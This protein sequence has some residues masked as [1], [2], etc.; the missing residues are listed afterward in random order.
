MPEGKMTWALV[1]LLPLYMEP[2]SGVAP[3]QLWTLVING[4]FKIVFLG[5][6]MYNTMF[7]FYRAAEG[8]LPETSYHSKLTLI[9]FSVI[10]FHYLMFQLMWALTL[11]L[12]T[13]LV[14]KQDRDPSGFTGESIQ[15]D[16]R[17]KG[18]GATI[19]VLFGIFTVIL[20]YRGMR[21]WS[22]IRKVSAKLII[23]IVIHTV[24]LILSLV[25][26]SISIFYLNNAFDIF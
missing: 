9:P 16:E 22:L 2:F 13:I 25:T 19:V 15:S 11:V 21:A 20:M 17:V 26:T 24:T 23:Q 12:Y 18:L 14:S 10:C 7:T 8:I 5:F 3:S 4:I 6:F 1:V